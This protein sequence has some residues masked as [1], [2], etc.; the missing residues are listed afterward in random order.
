MVRFAE[1]DLCDSIRTVAVMRRREFLK[2]IGAAA[3]ASGA[4]AA[5]AACGSE[6]T[7]AKPAA[8]GATTAEAATTTAAATSS[9]V[10]TVA[11]VTTVAAPKEKRAVKLGFIALTDAA[12][13]IMAKELGYFEERG[14]DAEI[15]KQA[16]WPALRDALQTKQIDAAHCLYSMPFSVA[17]KIGGNGATDLKIAMILNNNGQAITLAKEFASVG[18][19]DLTKAKA[20]LAS[21][22]A[23]ELAMTF[24]GGTHDLW[25][26]YWLAACGVDSST[27]KIGPV[28]PPQMV[29]NMTVGNVKGYCVGEPWNAVAVTKDIGFTTLATQDLWLH[30][31]EKALVANEA[32]ATE[33][34][35]TLKDVMAAVLKASKWLD[36]PANRAKAADTLGTEKYVN[37]KPDDIRGR[38]TGVYELGAG[39]GKKEFAGEQMQFFRDGN[40]NFPR[41]SYG[42][43]ALAQ[44]QRL[45]LLKDTPDYAKL[46]SSIILT[47]LYNE[48]ATAEKIAVPDDDMKPFEVRLDKTMFD[49]AKPEAEVARKVTP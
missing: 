20:L 15:I 41:K 45:G 38:L 16:S 44:Y 9:A 34:K 3:G 8:V 43:W 47:D 49:P 24:P 21:A 30:H 7:T 18:Y 36:D 37:A 35:D 10:T 22:Q 2:Q 32:F 11:P 25:I 27:L 6:T 14:I 39:L 33:K 19:G 1:T 23:P 5:L 17:T 40:T 28:P 42:V 13:I 26:R 48:V 12:S 46:T 31:P 29:Q 4:A